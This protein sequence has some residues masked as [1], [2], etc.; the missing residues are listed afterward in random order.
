MTQTKQKISTRE[1]QKLQKR[2]LE[3][4]QVKTELLDL[5]QRTKLEGTPDVTADDIASVVASMTGIPLK[6]LTEEERSKLSQLE[7]RIHERIVGQDEA[8][9]VVSHALRRSRAGLKDPRRPIGSFL[10]LGPTGVGKSELSNTLA[11]V[12]Y[13]SDDMLV[14]IDMSEFMEKHTVSRLIGAPPGYVG[15]DDGG[16]LTEVIRRRPFSVILFDEIE[17]AHPEVFNVLLQI[18]EDGRLTDGRG[19]VVDFKNCILI[20]TSN[21]GSELIYESTVGFS[22][23]E[24]VRDGLPSFEELRSRVMDALRV[25]FRPEF[26]NRIDEMVVF[27]SLSREDIAAITVRE[28][29]KIVGRMAD[30]EMKVTYT[31]KVVEYLAKKGYDPTYGARPL[32]RLLQKEIENPLSDGVIAGTFQ[33]GDTVKLGVL[34]GALTLT[35]KVTKN[36]G[37]RK[38]NTNN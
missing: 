6:D 3:L 5:W 15:F 13:G 37:R 25:S 17:K 4:Y 14:R 38:R 9:R 31:K 20:M 16:Q 10:F 34:K 26:L 27:S 24:A 22:S 30:Q 36:N 12:L 32:K 8:V 29:D 19:R 35:K 7:E 21:I 33:R 28:L 11:E 23:G 18:M 2:L 1:V